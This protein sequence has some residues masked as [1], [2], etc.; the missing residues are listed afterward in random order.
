[1]RPPTNVGSEKDKINSGKVLSDKEK[2]IFRVLCENTDSILGDFERDETG[3]DDSELS[4]CESVFA[5]EETEKVEVSEGADKTDCKWDS[6]SEPELESNISAGLKK[7]GNVKKRL[8]SEHALEDI[9]GAYGDEKAKDVR[10]KRLKVLE[11]KKRQIDSIDKASLWY[12]ERRQEMKSYLDDKI[13]H[14]QNGTWQKREYD[15]SSELDELKSGN[16]I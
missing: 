5:E 11:R 14:S 16:D 8:M 9:L 7:L 1:M 10:S 13:K 12:D 3:D 6:L 4:D 2:A 15:W